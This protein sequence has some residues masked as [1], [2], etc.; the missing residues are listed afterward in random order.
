MTAEAPPSKATGHPRAFWFIFWGEFAE[1]YSFYGMRA[2][3]PLYLTGVLHYA[4]NDPTY[5]RFKMAVYFLP[6]L[7]GFLA[8]RFIG[9]YW[10]IVGFSVPYVLGHFMLGIENTTALV[11]AL[12]LLALGS[13][14]TK[15]NISTLM[16]MTYDQQRPG[17]EQLLS[18]AF[19]WFYFSIN[20]GAFLSQAILPKIR[21]HYKEELGLS[22]AYQIA[23][24]APAWLMIAALII[25]AL[26]KRFYAVETPGRVVTTPEQAR[27]KWQALRT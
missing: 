17:Q 26:G 15:P 4:D 23:F 3:L 14:V 2:I 24:Q 12:S 8:D 16:G 20:I 1:R 19:R 13:G 5:Y 21:D 22:R 6:L 27:Q 9:K 11:I 25:F 10:A 18:S 7:G